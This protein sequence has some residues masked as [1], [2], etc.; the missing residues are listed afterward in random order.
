[1]WLP[2]EGTKRF[3]CFLFVVKGE[4]NRKGEFGQLV[5]EEGI[6]EEKEVFKGNGKNV[7]LAI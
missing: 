6:W 4:R 1:M 2:K 5:R 3:F 7:L